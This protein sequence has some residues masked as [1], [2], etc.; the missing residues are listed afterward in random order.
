M[1]TAA[2]RRSAARCDPGRREDLPPEGE[3]PHPRG[4][5]GRKLRVLRAERPRCRALP[6]PRSELRGG[7][8]PPCW[9][10]IPVRWG[11]ERSCSEDSRCAPKQPSG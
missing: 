6:T 5:G 1:V 2:T 8:A 7:G 10:L 3:D 4:E 11:Q 9:E